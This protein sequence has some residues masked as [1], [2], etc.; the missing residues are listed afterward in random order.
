M[1]SKFLAILPLAL[2]V[3]LSDAATQWNMQ[4]KDSQLTFVGTQAGAPLEGKF[5]KF[6]ADIRFDPKDLATSRFDV[7]IDMASVNT[8][9]G[10]R[11]SALKG[12]DLFNVKQFA[13]A[14]FVADTFTDKGKGR[15]AATGKLTIRNVTKDVPIEFT[16]E[17]K[18]DG[19]W[20]KGSAAIKRLGFGVGQ[21]VWKDTEAV[22]N[23]VKIKSALLLKQ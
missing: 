12:A 13:S 7:K 16:F 22:A 5:E 1:R 3:T 14:Q 20:L 23:D 15:Y 10:E 2:L 19:A 18:D 4:P 9:D 6:T 21:G 17:Q 8:R 11:D